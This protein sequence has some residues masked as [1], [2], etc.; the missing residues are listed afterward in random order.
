MRT[1]H[2]SLLIN[3]TKPPGT[4]NF[5]LAGRESRRSGGI[6][7]EVPQHSKVYRRRRR[8]IVSRPTPPPLSSANRPA[9]I[10]LLR[11]MLLAHLPRTNQ[12]VSVTT[13]TQGTIVLK[14]CARQ[15]MTLEAGGRR[16][17]S[18]QSRE[19]RPLLSCAYLTNGIF[20][21]SSAILIGETK[22]GLASGLR[23]V[24]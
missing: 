13:G 21:R 16:P 7:E 5:S 1:T 20:R 23:P 10:V 4:R 15:V 8:T 22:L 2:V 14:G 19:Y 3:D 17:R 24:Q 9:N 18:R 12:G 6:D 11:R